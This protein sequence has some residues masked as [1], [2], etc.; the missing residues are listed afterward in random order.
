VKFCS[1]DQN[2]GFFKF[3]FLILKKKRVLGLNLPSLDHLFLQVAK[4]EHCYNCFYNPTY[5]E[6]KLA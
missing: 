6:A 2:Q 5:H 1:S 3:Y 4:Q